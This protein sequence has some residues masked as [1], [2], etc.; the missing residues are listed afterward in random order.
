MSKPSSSF[1][2]HICGYRFGTKGSLTVHLKQT[3]RCKPKQEWIYPCSWCERGFD[4]PDSYRRHRQKCHPG[5]EEVPHEHMCALCHGVYPDWFRF[6]LHLHW[7]HSS[8]RGVINNNNDDGIPSE[9]G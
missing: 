8:M 3:K 5:R 1:R 2:C 4:A 6:K 9:T 7:K